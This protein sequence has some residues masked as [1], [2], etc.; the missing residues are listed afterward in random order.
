MTRRA[1]RIAR[2]IRLAAAEELK[3]RRAM[4]SA[5]QEHKQATERLDEL[6]RYRREY[7]ASKQQRTNVSALLLRD[8][9]AFLERLD[10]AASGQR[11]L[12]LERDHNIEARRQRWLAC[13]RRVQSLKA[14]RGRLA[15]TER[16]AAM[17]LEQ[18]AAD[19]IANRGKPRDGFG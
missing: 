6:E 18:K 17:R 14:M 19:D 12:I 9:Q 13:R 11:Q 10:R 15:L 4:A 7:A 2:L 3:A 5:V 8:H 1:K 16:T